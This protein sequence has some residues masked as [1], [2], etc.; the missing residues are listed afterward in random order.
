MCRH[1]LAPSCTV[2]DGSLMV[3]VVRWRF[4][5]CT[6]LTTSSFQSTG[7]FD[8]FG[9][10]PWWFLPVLLALV[11]WSTR[12]LFQSSRAIFLFLVPVPFQSPRAIF[13]AGGVGHG[14]FSDWGYL[15]RGSD[16][17]SGLWW[18]WW[19]GWPWFLPKNSCT[20]GIRFACT[21]GF[22]TGSN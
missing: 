7:T 20:L 18:L 12:T 9:M 6:W 17:L 1:Q 11:A 13:I 16:W 15:G 2:S 5:R 14:R 4:R 21:I 22:R 10:G 3:L 8:I 19:R